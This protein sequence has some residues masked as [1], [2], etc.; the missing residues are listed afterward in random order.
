MT[1]NPYCRTIW[2]PQALHLPL[3]TY[4]RHHPT[5]SLSSIVRRALTAWLAKEGYQ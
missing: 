3:E 2:V 5:E 1:P 4:R